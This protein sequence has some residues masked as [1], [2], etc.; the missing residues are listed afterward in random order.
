MPRRF[1]PLLL[2]LLLG[3]CASSPPR[4]LA[5]GSG[6]PRVEP[7]LALERFLRAVNARD[8]QT[9]AQLFGTEDGSIT[10]QEPAPDVE[11]RMFALARLLRHSDYHV[12]GQQIVP[13]RL[14]GAVQLLVELDL[15]DRPVTVPFTLV[16]T[17]AGDWLVEEIDI[18]PILSH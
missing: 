14:G 9:M 15:A 16:R 13:G 6:A 18:D 5:S 17:G 4:P 7:S 2:A 12:K 1:A 11:R 3:A 8:L 10:R